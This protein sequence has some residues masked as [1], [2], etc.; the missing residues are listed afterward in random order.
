MRAIA[1]LVVVAACS[2]PTKHFEGSIDAPSGSADAPTADAP[3]GT[4]DARADAHVDATVDAG[5]TAMRGAVVSI[6]DVTVIDSDAKSLGLAGGA[7]VAQFLDLTQ[8]GG[9]LLYG[10]S[11][12]GSCVVTQYSI[13]QNKLPNPSVDAG[14][15]T[16][17]G[18]GLLRPVGP[19]TYTNALN[20][21]ECVSQQATASITASSSGGIAHYSV[22]GGNFVNDSTAAYLDVHGFSNT[23]F[24]GRNPIGGA[25]DSDA[26]GTLDELRVALPNPPPIGTT[27]TKTMTYKIVDGAGPFPAG[28]FGASPDYLASTVGGVQ[29]V[30]RVQK[31]TAPDWPAID[32]T[33]PVRGEG[34]ALSTAGDL[35]TA[36]PT[37]A[38]DVQFTCVGTGGNC[39]AEVTPPSGQI[40]GTLIVGSTTDGNVTGLPNFVMP[41]PVNTFTTFQCAY[42]LSDSATIP[43]AAVQA[44]LSTNPKRIEISV[45]RVTAAIVSGN[46]SA[47]S[48]NIL[49]GHAIVGHTTP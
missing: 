29:G 36:F 26:N 37:T 44:I 14:T 11:P 35:P 38:R 17:S 2:F 28:L 16:I 1:A 5:P 30:V 9:T 13:P 47:E 49:V 25:V 23:Q 33:I 31:A 22:N 46:N 24:N 34:Y 45:A 48:G 19:C 6:D 15:V 40:K 39:G 18:N 41:P 3:I 27:E 42:L 21:Y 4:A 43:Q 7:I 20:P 8:G 32:V 10:S 12:I